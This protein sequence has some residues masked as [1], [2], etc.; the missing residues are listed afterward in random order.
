MVFVVETSEEDDF[1]MTMRRNF[2]LET[3]HLGALS[4]GCSDRDISIV[5]P[6]K[7]HSAIPS[8]SYYTLVHKFFL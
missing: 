5:P 7:Y 1:A 8:K 4:V 3:V 2:A 6:A